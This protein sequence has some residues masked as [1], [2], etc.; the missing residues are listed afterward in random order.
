MIWKKYVN[1]KS[2]FRD[3]K[4]IVITYISENI[5]LIVSNETATLQ[6]MALNAH[7]SSISIN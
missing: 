7:S 3:N 5:E 4:R 1:F 6:Q 2:H